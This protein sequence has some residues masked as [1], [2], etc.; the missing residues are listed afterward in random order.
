MPDKAVERVC[1]LV[2]T[3]SLDGGGCLCN[4]LVIF[5]DDPPV[6]RLLDLCEIDLPCSASTAIHLEE[7]AGIPDL[8]GEVAVTLKPCR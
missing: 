2:E 6:D 4:C 3:I 5:G 1:R 8:G 7:T